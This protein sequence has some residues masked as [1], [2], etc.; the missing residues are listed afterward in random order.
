MAREMA[1]A[2]ALTTAASTTAENLLNISIAVRRRYCSSA[3]ACESKVLAGSI[4]G[5]SDVTASGLTVQS[6]EWKPDNVR[7]WR[8][9]LPAVLEAVRGHRQPN[10]AY[11]FGV[12][13]GASM[14]LYRRWWPQATL[15]GF[16]SFAGL[17]TERR[18]EVRRATWNRGT[19]DVAGE[20]QIL[21]R[22]RRDLG[23]RRT[24]L[25]KGYFN[26]SLTTALAATLEPA[27]LVDIDSDIYVSAYEALEWL[28]KHRLAVVG[29]VIAYDDWADYACAPLLSRSEL[30]ALPREQVAA[31]WSLG[32]AP[33]SRSSGWRDSAVGK[34]VRQSATRLSYP[35]LFA[36]GEPKAHRQIAHR[37][38]V[39]FRCVAGSC[40]AAQP[41]AARSCDPHNAYGAV[42]VVTSVGGPPDDGVEMADGV[43]LDHWRR[44]DA[45][46]KYVRNHRFTANWTDAPE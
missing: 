28:F 27:D 9:T 35:P 34:A 7:C 18:G 19:F 31:A 45:A 25:F 39:A 16:D 4:H 13:R 12:F 6:G 23:P 2:S 17:P 36:A 24:Q 29:T 33:P 21:H 11:T 46:C 8:L 10:V 40:K 15:L 1:S 5:E 44:R 22:I 20:P 3:N 43:E 30:D 38:G 37:F 26:E 42:F 14:Y 41:P 32:F